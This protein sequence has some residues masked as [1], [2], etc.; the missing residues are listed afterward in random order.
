M[1]ALSIYADIALLKTT[2]LIRIT[3]LQVMKAA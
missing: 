1:D 2:A 3:F